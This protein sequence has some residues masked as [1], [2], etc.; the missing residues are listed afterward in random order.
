MQL[1]GKIGSNSYANLG[2]AVTITSSD[3]NGN[4]S[5][6]ATAAEFEAL[7]GFTDGTTD[8][9]TAV[10]TDK[11]GNSKTFTVMSSA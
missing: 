10:I 6:T 5:A 2:S 3:L 8:T 11:A 9:I 7:T 4:I 1:R